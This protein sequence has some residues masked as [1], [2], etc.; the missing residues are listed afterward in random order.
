MRMIWMVALLV[1]VG[2]SVA[3]AGPT[4]LPGKFRPV[5][6]RLD[7][8]RITPAIPF[9][10]NCGDVVPYNIVS[11]TAPPPPGALPG[12]N[13]GFYFTPGLMHINAAAIVKNVGTQPSGGTEGYQF[14]TVTQRP[15]GGAPETEL[16]RA[17][18]RPLRIRAVQTFPFELRIPFDTTRGVGG[19]GAWTLTMSLTFDKRA[20]VTLRPAD[21][22]LTNNILV[23]DLRLW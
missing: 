5:A 2:A 8:V 4:P 11:R 15:T 22:V 19:P 14:V 21:C 12:G 23:R 16:L 7:D 17:S 6:P 20:P 1:V 9:A 13:L 18:F 10:P 3:A